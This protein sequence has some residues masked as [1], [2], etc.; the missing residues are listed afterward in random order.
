MKIYYTNAMSRKM[1][2]TVWVNEKAYA[3]A[4]RSQ[5]ELKVKRGDVVKYRVGRFSAMRTLEFQSPDAVFSIEPNKKLQGVYIAIM[6]AVLLVL[7]YMRQS[8][9]MWVT[10]LVVV[11]IFGYE[12]STYY[13][14]YVAKPVHN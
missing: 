5:I 14:G 4:S 6:L 12:A 8:S 7:W 10:A 9:S 1:T 13:R 2:A 3:V 11:M